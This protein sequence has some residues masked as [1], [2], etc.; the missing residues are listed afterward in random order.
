[1][2][3]SATHVALEEFADGLEAW[4]MRTGSEKHIIGG[5]HTAKS[6]TVLPRWGFRLFKSLTG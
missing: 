3:S 4:D 1:M 5:S 2:F 6:P